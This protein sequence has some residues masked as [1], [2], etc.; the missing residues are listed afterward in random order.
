MVVIRDHWLSEGHS[1]EITYFLLLISHRR[2]IEGCYLLMDTYELAE[3]DPYV[4]QVTQMKYR[5]EGDFNP[6]DFL[7]LQI[8][9]R[10]Y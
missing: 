8:K 3:A 10:V 6:L 9:P 7:D 1:N 4:R 2:G 5:L